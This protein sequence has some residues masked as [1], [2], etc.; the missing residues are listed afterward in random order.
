MT[1]KPAHKLK[2]LITNFLVL[3]ILIDF[4]RWGS[5]LIDFNRKVSKDKKRPQV[6]LYGEIGQV[7]LHCRIIVCFNVLFCT[8]TRAE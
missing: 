1:I 8:V 2:K 3:S 6:E 5:I 4:W 7:F